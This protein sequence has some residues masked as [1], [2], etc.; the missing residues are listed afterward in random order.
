[1]RPDHPSPAT[2]EP[3]NP[4]SPAS[5]TAAPATRPK[6]NLQKRSVPDAVLSPAPST[7]ESKASPFGGARPI[8]TAAREREVEE[9]RQ[10]A[11]RQKRETDEKAK[12]EK[13]DKQRQAKD[14]AKGAK[15]A[16]DS[17]GKDGVDTSQG[18]KSFEILRRAVEDE[19]GM[20]ADREPEEQ[21]GPAAEAKGAKTTAPNEPS[22][23]NGAWRNKPADSAEAADDEGW[24]TV[25]SRQR[26]NRRGQAGRT[27][28]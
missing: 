17:D 12:A 14:Q 4:P 20:T 27:L 1:M 19:S 15:A 16:V 23:A 11:I 18:G 21:A 22:S 7:T 6:L 3:S 2:K 13:S 28:A 5:S 8:D 26:S 24:S 10:L 25:G 9:R